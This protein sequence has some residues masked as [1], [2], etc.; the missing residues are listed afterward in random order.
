MTKTLSKSRL[1]PNK[2]KRK[3]RI[4]NNISI[5]SPISPKFNQKI[6]IRKWFYSR[7]MSPEDFHLID[8]E[9]IDI[10]FVNRE[11]L[12]FCDQQGVNLDNC[13]HN[14]K[15][16][17]GDIFNY[18]QIR[19]SCLQYEKIVGKDAADPVDRILIDGDNIRLVNIAFAFCFK[20]A[21]LA[22]TGGGDIEHTKYVGQVST[23][24]RVLTSRDGDLKSH[25]AKTDEAEA[26]IGNT[27][28]KHL[29][30]NNRDI[31]GNKG[32]IKG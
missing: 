4:E 24:M 5:L 8:K 7:E 22:A 18:H 14:I 30:I 17:F 31:A 20:E 15:I 23:N 13:D 25:F 16:I 9:T 21:K 11:F 19:N 6:I 28:L 29:L 1:R 26:Q 3:P 32:K 12:K 27:S 10:S 2:L